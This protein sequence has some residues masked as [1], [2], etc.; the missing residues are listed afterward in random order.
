MIANVH[1]YMMIRYHV[2]GQLA[3]TNIAVENQLV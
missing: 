2:S 1:T 3:Y